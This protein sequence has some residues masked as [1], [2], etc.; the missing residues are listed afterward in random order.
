MTGDLIDIKTLGR[1][2]GVKI[3]AGTVHNVYVYLV[4]MV[5]IVNNIALTRYNFARVICIHLDFYV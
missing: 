3:F 4:Y 1:D 2:L 5:Y